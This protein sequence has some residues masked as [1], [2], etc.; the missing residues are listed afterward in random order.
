MNTLAIFLAL[1]G[2]AVLTVSLVAGLL[3]YR[4]ILRQKDE[5]GW[6][7]LH[8]GGSGRGV[9]LLALAATIHLSALPAWLMWSVAGFILF[10]A[11][12]STLAM[13]IVAMTGERGFGWSGPMANKVAFALYAT[14]TAA[15]LPAFLVLM[16]GL[17][18]AL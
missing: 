18:V 16:T 7:L 8:A 13:I 5:H 9:M 10:F 6:H 11:W 15:V 14:G 4:A 12:T 17:A 1:N 3:L 2:A